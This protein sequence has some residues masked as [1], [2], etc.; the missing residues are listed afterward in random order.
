ML[1]VKMKKTTLRMARRYGKLPAMYL[2]AEV[3]PE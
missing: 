1:I 2:I 3:Q